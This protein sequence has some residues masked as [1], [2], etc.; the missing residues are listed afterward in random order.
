MDLN[1]LEICCGP[2][3]GLEFVVDAAGFERRVAGMASSLALGWKPAP[4]I[5]SYGAGRLSVRD[6][7]HRYAALRRSGYDRYWVVVWF[8]SPGELEAFQT[9]RLGR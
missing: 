9:A 4:L 7:N 1:A 6:G 5:V 3:P 8:N 2:D